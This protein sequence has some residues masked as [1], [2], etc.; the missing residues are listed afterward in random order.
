MIL[1]TFIS[2]C[3]SETPKPSFE[4]TVIGQHID[5]TIEVDS[6]GAVLVNLLDDTVQVVLSESAVQFPQDLLQSFD[7]DVAVS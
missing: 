4:C 5:R 1:M 6:A 3:L 7:G 2:V